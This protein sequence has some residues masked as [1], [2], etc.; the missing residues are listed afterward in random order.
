MTPRR[1]GHLLI[2]CAVIWLLFALVVAASDVR[3][4]T[5]ELLGVTFTR[6]ELARLKAHAA[7]DASD[8]TV[9]H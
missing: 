6:E 5:I 1:V 9:L 3:S 4:D 8:L 7:I 2:A